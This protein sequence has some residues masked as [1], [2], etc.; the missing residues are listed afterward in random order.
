MYV[1]VA[2]LVSTCSLNSTYVCI[3]FL[4]FQKT[5]EVYE[6]KQR[7]TVL[8]AELQ[9]GRVAGR[10]LSSKQHKLDEETLK[11]QEILYTQDFQLQQQERKVARLMGERSDEEQSALSDKIKVCLWY[12]SK[13]HSEMHNAWQ[14]AVLAD[15]STASTSPVLGNGGRECYSTTK[16][17]PSQGPAEGPA[18]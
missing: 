4:Q 14:M 5:Q 11:Q 3:C 2:S 13:L 6:C 10:N 12:L 15:R 7:E 16:G 8:N 1:A 17:A 18:G 9:G